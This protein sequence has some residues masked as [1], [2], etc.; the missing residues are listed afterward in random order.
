MLL[1][2]SLNNFCEDCDDYIYQIYDNDIIGF[3]DIKIEEK[4]M[5]ELIKKIN[6]NN[7]ISEKISKEISNNIIFSKI[8]EN[9]IEELSK[10]EEIIFKILVNIII[11]DYKNYPNLIHFFNIRNLLYFF[12]IEDKSKDK[13]GNII[14]DNPIEN[15]E[16]IIIEYINNI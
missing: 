11:N 4:K 15:N 12:N 1:K 9:N 16:S 10:E 6:D 8:N 14:D 5:E 13:E 3:D 2:F 7:D